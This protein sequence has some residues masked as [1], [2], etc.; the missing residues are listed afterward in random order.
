MILGALLL[1]LESARAQL[2]GDRACV[3]AVACSVQDNYTTWT[4]MNK[5]VDGLVATNIVLYDAHPLTQGSNINCP[6]KDHS[7]HLWST[8]FTDRNGVM[9][10]DGAAD[11][12]SCVLGLSRTAPSHW[13]WPDSRHPVPGGRERCG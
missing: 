13:P 5:T 11:S 8:G 9:Y 7:C 6:G 2:C 10:V 3:T 1:L 4:M 12:L